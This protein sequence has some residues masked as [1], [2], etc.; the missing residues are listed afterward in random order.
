MHLPLKTNKEVKENPGLLNKGK[1]YT[2]MIGTASRI[3]PSSVGSKSV[4]AGSGTTEPT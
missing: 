4:K 1:R 2:W 3:S